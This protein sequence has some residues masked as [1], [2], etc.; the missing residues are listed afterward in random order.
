MPCELLSLSRSSSGFPFSR[1]CFISLKLVS[2][3][4]A[5]VIPELPLRCPILK[6]CSFLKHDG[7]PLSISK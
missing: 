5:A 4:S 1:A 3:L 2:S 6:G 7:R